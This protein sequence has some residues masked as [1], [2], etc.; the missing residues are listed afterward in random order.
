MVLSFVVETTEARGT[1]QMVGGEVATPPMPG[2]RTAAAIFQTSTAG[3][4]KVL[5]VVVTTAPGVEGRK[6]VVVAT[7][8]LRPGDR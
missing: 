6:A 3:S 5:V 8:T 2:G 1:S 7:K 4:R